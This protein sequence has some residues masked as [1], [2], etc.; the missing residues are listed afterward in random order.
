MYVWTRTPSDQSVLSCCNINIST[1]GRKLTSNFTISRLISLK[2][3]FTKKQVYYLLRVAV[4]P[5]SSQLVAVGG[6]CT[7]VTVLLSY[8]PDRQHSMNVGEV[9]IAEDSDFALLKVRQKFHS[10]VSFIEDVD[11]FRIK[12]PISYF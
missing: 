6:V 11:Y 12:I 5:A 4:V 2:S 1:Q 7:G 10:P 9:R 8:S 3:L